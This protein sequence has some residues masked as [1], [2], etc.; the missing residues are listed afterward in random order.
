MTPQHPAAEREDAGLTALA[1]ALRWVVHKYPHKDGNGATSRHEPPNAADVV[2]ALAERG[3]VLR[4]ADHRSDVGLR[5]LAEKI[6]AEQAALPVAT[7]E[8][9]EVRA[10]LPDGSLLTEVQRGSLRGQGAAL[11]WVLNLINELPAAA[12]NP[13]RSGAADSAERIWNAPPGEATNR[14]V[15]AE[16]AADNPSSTTARDDHEHTVFIHKHGGVEHHHAALVVPGEALR[17]LA[18]AW[19]DARNV[20]LAEVNK[21]P[22][23]PPDEPDFGPWERMRAAES[24]FWRAALSA[25]ATTETT[26]DDAFVVCGIDGC[27]FAVERG[28]GRTMALHQSEDHGDDRP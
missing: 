25:P 15:A 9:G 1:E 6:R 22:V 5:E 24:A 27:D 17:T 20:Y 8:P 11:G 23:I 12:D 7:I 3:Y 14:A 26:P 2:A 13:S 10:T 19:N 18:L 16:F 21:G 4:A 28:E